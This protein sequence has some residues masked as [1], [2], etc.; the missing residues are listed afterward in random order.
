MQRHL[1]H[2]PWADPALVRMPGMRPV[3]GQWIVVDEAYSAQIALRVQLLRDRRAAVT[4]SLPGAE[5]AMAEALE[6]VIAALPSGFR[7]DGG[8]VTCPDGRVV[9]IGGPPFDVLA[10]LVQEDILL[11]ERRD[12]EHILIAGLLCFPSL[13]TLGE[14][15]GRPLRRIHRPVERYDADV[16]HRVQRLLDRAPPGRAMWR[17]N[18]MGYD[19]PSLHRPMR[20]GASRPAGPVRYVRS[21]RQTILRLPRTGAALFAIHV[22]V[23]ALE[24]LTP[25]Q[26]EGCP[27]L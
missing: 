12:M 16:A 26:R 22:W 14:K 15:I 6:A 20:E 11:L 19:E 21:E 7:R 3:E 9:Q 25:A 24:D 27:F 4:A 5:P 8:A 10:Q 1:P 17:A 18:A 2:A 23:V 13:W